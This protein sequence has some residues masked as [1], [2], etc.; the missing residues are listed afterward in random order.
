MKT[1]RE[2]KYNTKPNSTSFKKGHKKVGGIGKGDKM[3][4]S[5]KEKIRLSL[6][7]KDNSKSRNWKGGVSPQNKRKN[8]PR[9]MPEKCE[10]C[11]RDKKVSTKGLHY[12]HCHKTGK[13]RGW[14]C[15]KCNVALGM[16]GD[17]VDILEKLIIYLKNNE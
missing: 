3:S 1:Q 2:R 7:G 12:D 6:V 4:T 8:A 16:V 14:L 17:S 13:F 11:N 9:P 5:S 15:F 10:V